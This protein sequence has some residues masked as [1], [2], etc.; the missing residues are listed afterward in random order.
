MVR[1]PVPNELDHAHQLRHLPAP[2]REIARTIGECRVNC[3]DPQRR[4]IPTLDD[5]P[6]E[7]Q[8]EFCDHL[9]VNLRLAATTRCTTACCSKV[10]RSLRIQPNM[11]E[12]A[13]SS[14]PLQRP[15]P[16]FAVD[17]VADHHFDHGSQ[18][19]Q[20]LTSADVPLVQPE[21]GLQ[22][23]SDRAEI[24]L[25]PIDRDA[26][27]DLHDVPRPGHYGC[28]PFLPMSDRRIREH[29]VPHRPDGRHHHIATARL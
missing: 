16:Q 22:V 14:M 4:V 20:R 25:Q 28:Q 18:T 19:E 9:A 2:L 1:G 7:T 13:F 21:R 23:A 24:R 6:P 12:P 27:P 29:D 17:R 10:S 5:V 15:G 26:V 3:R 11:I 8:G